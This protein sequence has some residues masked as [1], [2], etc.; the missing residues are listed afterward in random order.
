MYTQKL[1]PITVRKT[2]QVT[3]KPHSPFEFYVDFAGDASQTLSEYF[4]KNIRQGHSFKL[5]KI[6]LGI[7]PK[8]NDGAD[9][10]VGLATTLQ[11]IFTP[12]TKHTRTA[13]NQ[14]FNEWRKQ[15]TLAGVV[16]ATVRY[17]DFE[18]AFDDV[19]ADTTFL[20]RRSVIYATGIGD[21][22]QE[23][24]SIQGA[25]VAGQHLSLKDYYEDRNPIM[26]PSSTP[27]GGVV[28]EPKF[29]S[30]WPENVELQAQ[31]SLSSVVTHID[32][33]IPTPGI[34]DNAFSGAVSMST[35]WEGNTDVFCGSM[36]CFAYVIADD[37]LS[38]FPDEAELTVTFW[39][40]KWT[41]LAQRARSTRKKSSSRRFRSAYRNRKSNRRYKRR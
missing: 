14:M 27:F 5:C 25:S 31:A 17:D 35:G 20:N 37:T 36:K 4:G 30:Y 10:D 32:N 34:A 3:D 40:A 21:S 7:Q 13:W 24:L 2:I 23:A 26:Q 28:K 8:E 11:T 38:Q 33:I 12:S 6:D 41:P 18:L 39:V 1:Y 15:K 9:Y 29:D 19:H 16:G 22:T